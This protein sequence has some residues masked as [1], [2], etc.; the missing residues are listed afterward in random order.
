M[1]SS[2]NF[3]SFIKMVHFLLGMLQYVTKKKIENTSKNNEYLPT[4][5]NS[6]FIL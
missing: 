5:K 3:H 6:K 2:N 4:N 1:F